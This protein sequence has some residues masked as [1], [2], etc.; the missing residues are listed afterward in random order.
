M[1]GGDVIILPDN[2]ALGMKHANKVAA[3]LWGKA[4]R[5]KCVELP[6]LPPKGDVVD[7]LTKYSSSDLITVVQSASAQ[8]KSLQCQDLMSREFCRLTISNN[9]AGRVDANAAH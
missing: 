8:M 5:I 2:D 1:Q 4:K 3:S 6:G 7:F 9:E